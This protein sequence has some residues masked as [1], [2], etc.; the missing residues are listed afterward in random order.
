M[1]GSLVGLWLGGSGCGVLGRLA[2]VRSW[3]PSADPDVC[4]AGPGEWA[5]LVSRQPSSCFCCGWA[6]GCRGLVL[7][8]GGF[9]FVE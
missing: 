4:S 9:P 5:G 1:C 6:D 3:S 2:A 7:G 8:V